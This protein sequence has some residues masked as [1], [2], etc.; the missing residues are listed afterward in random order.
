MDHLADNSEELTQL[1]NISDVVH[2]V[3][4]CLILVNDLPTH[5]SLHS[6]RK[7][8][9]KKSERIFSSLQ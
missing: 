8:N 7:T 6:S 2:Q 5:F 4:L 3:F 1:N 9:I